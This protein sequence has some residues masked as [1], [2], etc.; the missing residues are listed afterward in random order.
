MS[1]SSPH[2]FLVF[3][4]F[5]LGGIQRKM[6][7]ISNYLDSLSEEE[8]QNVVNCHLIVREKSNFNF[9][10]ELI[11]SRTELHYLPTL[12]F[13][14]RFKNVFYHFYL[15]YLTVKYKPK[16]ILS[17]LHFS[18]PSLIFI[19]ILL[20]PFF[21]FKLIVSQDNILSLYN[22][23]PH[24]KKRFPNWLIAW[25]YGFADKIIVQTEY[26][27]QDLVKNL[28]VEE[29]K[30][31]VIQNWVIDTNLQERDKKYD[32]VYCGR[33]APQ[34][35]LEKLLLLIKKLVK[36]KPNIKLLMIG[37]GDQKLKLTKLV[38]KWN[39]ENNVKFM[40]PTHQVKKYLEQSKLFILTSEFEGHPMILLEAM[41]LKVVP[42][43]LEYP[44]CQEYL[45]NGQ[46]SFIGKNIQELVNLT[47][48]LMEDSK[49]RSVA[50]SKAR[51]RVLTSNDVSLIKETLIAAEVFN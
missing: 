15:L 14:N 31:L 49:L 46:D 36:K 51:Q 33:F 1:S 25:L 4:N 10:K 20:K 39:L 35:N 45:R 43:V 8:N 2:L 28:N 50:G 32:L 29:D 44:G 5:G 17:F 37:D 48:R 30:I 38:K 6:T 19:K 21:R 23:K 7:D 9:E 27:K 34:K 26:A 16:A 24:V 40:R 11:N 3:H 47:E 18:L 42:V 12:P 22:K 13:L 41:I